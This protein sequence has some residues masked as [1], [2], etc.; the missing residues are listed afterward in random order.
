MR[1]ARRSA[2]K[3]KSVLL[4]RSLIENHRTVLFFAYLQLTQTKN[5]KQIFISK[6]WDIYSHEAV[7]L[8]SIKHTN[9]CF[10]YLY[11]LKLKCLL[12]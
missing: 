10:L 4:E 1:T 8:A 9:F 6:I 5:Y 11:C 3:D 2:K 12:Q 7:S